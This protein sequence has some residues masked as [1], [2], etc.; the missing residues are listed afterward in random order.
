[1]EGRTEKHGVWRKNP[2]EV[3]EGPAPAGA[4]A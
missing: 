4:S 2:Q 3:S 1:M